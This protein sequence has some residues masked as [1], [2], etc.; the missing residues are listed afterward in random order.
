VLIKNFKSIF[1]ASLIVLSAVMPSFARTE[2]ELTVGRRLDASTAVTTLGKVKSTIKTCSTSCSAGPTDSTIN[3]SNVSAERTVT[4]FSCNGRVGQR[5]EV[6]NVSGATTNSIIIDGFADETVG[7][8]ASKTMDGN[9]ASVEVMCI[10]NSAAVITKD[11]STNIAG[12]VDGNNSWTGN[13][14]FDGITTD[15]IDEVTS[16]A[17]VTID[18]VLLKDG[19]VRTAAGTGTPNTGVTAVTYGDGK[20]FTTVL[21]I[22]KADA[23]L[24]ADN[25]ALSDGYLLWTAPAG[26]EVIQAAYMTMAVTCAEDTTSTLDGGLGTTEGSGAQ[27]VLSGVGAA[28][29]N[30]LTGQTFANASGTAKVKTVADQVLVIATAGDHTVYFNAADTWANTAGLDLTCDIAGTVTIKWLKMS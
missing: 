18:S 1:L 8:S 19:T 12:E 30:I 4:L 20:S 28:A 10:S 17:G 23:L 29:E 24:V 22:S 26:E 27:S 15:A 6:N 11:T 7:G 3:V 2:Q 16:A 13:N 21:T 9:P 14:E 5:T 25:A